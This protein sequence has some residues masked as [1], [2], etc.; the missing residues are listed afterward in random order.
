MS[1]IHWALRSA[2]PAD[3]V[4]AHRM[5]RS[6]AAMLCMAALSACAGPNGPLVS[7]VDPSD[8]DAPVAAVGYRSTL[9][10]YESMRPVAPGNW[11]QQNQSVGPQ[12]K[13]EPSR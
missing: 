1:N 3:R 9:S 11:R 7:G 4:P 5:A 6:C 2:V 13:A 10:P 12:P 8:P